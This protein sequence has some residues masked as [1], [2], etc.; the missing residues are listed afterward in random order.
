MLL[1]HLLQG[2]GEIAEEM[3]AIGDLGGGR[4]P[5]ARPVG[6]GGRAGARDHLDPR[7]LPEPLR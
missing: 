1:E 7:M 5:V 3:N 2:L 6:V 4:G